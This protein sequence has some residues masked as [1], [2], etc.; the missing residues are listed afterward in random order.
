MTPPVSNP[1]E[2]LPTSDGSVLLGTLSEDWT[3]R[4]AI[5]YLHMAEGLA[6]RVSH[7]SEIREQGQ[8]TVISLLNESPE[9]LH[10][11]FMCH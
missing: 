1:K 11:V 5:Q 6:S 10:H 9:W 3:L 2:V 7:F 8:D 4:I